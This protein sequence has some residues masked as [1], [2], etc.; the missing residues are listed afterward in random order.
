MDLTTLHVTVTPPL[1]IASIVAGSDPQSVTLQ[2][3]LQI[4]AHPYLVHIDTGFDTD[5]NTISPRHTDATFAGFGSPPDTRPPKITSPASNQL[6]V[7]VTTVGA[8]LSWTSVDGARRYVVQASTDDFATIAAEN[9]DVRA[10]STHLVLPAAGTYE[11]RVRADVTV[12]NVY[13]DPGTFIGLDDAV[14]VY[15]A[16]PGTCTGGIG[17]SDSPAGSIGVG[18]ALAVGYGVHE[19]W[20]AGPATYN[21]VIR[22]PDGMSI[23]GGYTPTFSG[24]DLVNNA[25]TLA[26]APVV[27]VDVPQSTKPMEVDGLTIRSAGVPDRTTGIQATAVS[28]NLTIRDCDISLTGYEVTGIAIYNPEMKPESAPLI[29]HNRINVQGAGA[30]VHV[31][32][33]RAF[34]SRIVNNPLLHTECHGNFVNDRNYVVAVYF[35]T[36]EKNIVTSTCGDEN[37][38]SGNTGHMIY[39]QGCIHAA[40]NLLM[41]VPDMLTFFFSSLPGDLAF[42]TNVGTPLSYCAYG[43]SQ[44]FIVNNTVIATGNKT[45]VTGVT[46]FIATNNEQPFTAI[47]NLVVGNRVAPS[48]FWGNAGN[49]PDNGTL[50]RNMGAVLDVGAAPTADNDF[51]LAGAS[52]TAAFNPFSLSQNHLTSSSPDY[53]IHQGKLVP[54][55]TDDLDGK[56][57]TCPS[58]EQCVSLG[59]YELDP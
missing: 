36:F 24:R 33:I 54:T 1:E 27:F 4:A 55:V 40:N 34:A 53:A 19:V 43:E 30:P 21:E 44:S 35:A 3:D 23:R 15:C 32:A 57:R 10:I 7:E 18:V 42:S 51:S 28:A 37:G 38:G 25:A 20:I 22:V 56:P 41:P 16:T 29:T 13:S 5:G 12:D 11:W 47:N 26:G 45:N 48:K 17:T 8:A 50:S 2:T 9:D 14:R 46:E 59:A 58:P 52:G 49:P 39:T 31:S 6:L